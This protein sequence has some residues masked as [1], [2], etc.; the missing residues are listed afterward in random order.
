MG[1]VLVKNNKGGVGKTWIAL[2]LAAYKAFEKNE[3]VLILTSDSQNN[4]LNYS[5]IKIQ[6]TSKAGLEDMLENKKFNLTK[7]RPNLFFLHIQGYKLGDNLNNN[8]K[9]KIKELKKEFKHIVIDASPVMDLDDAFIQISEHIIVPT[10]SDSVT[11]QSILNMLKKSE[12]NKI[13][14]IVPNR[15]G[16]TK[17]EKVWFEFLQ[18]KLKR[19]GIFLS[20]PIKQSAVILNMIEKGT[21]L[22]ES[23]AKKLDEI[24]IIFERIW[25]E[26][27]N[28]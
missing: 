22:W 17:T 9:L 25:K 11:S 16:R 1:V 6:D 2:Q 28:E 21:L 18:E 14:A 3:K 7:L 19:T 5:G 20:T 26:I 8:F 15:A 10:F 23:K 4:I 12:I 13:R 24:K 27:D